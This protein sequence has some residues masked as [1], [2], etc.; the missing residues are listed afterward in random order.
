MD[1]LA[2]TEVLAQGREAAARGDWPL[3]YDAL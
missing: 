3:A 2:G 1:D